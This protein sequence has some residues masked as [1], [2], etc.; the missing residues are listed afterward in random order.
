MKRILITGA[1]GFVGSYC[2]RRALELGYDVWAVRSRNAPSDIST[3]GVTWRTVD[4]LAPGNIEALLEE[5]RPTHALHTA[6]VTEHGAYWNSVKNLDWLALGLRFFRR[7]GEL[8]GQRFVS[9]GTC[10]EYDWAHGYMVEGLTPD[11]PQTFYGKIKLA[12]HLALMAVSEEM[13]FSAATGRIFFAY[14]PKENPSRFVPSLCQSFALSSEA[15]IGS[16]NFYRDFMHVEDVSNGILALLDSNINGICNVSSGQPARLREIANIL[17]EIS[18]KQHL[19]QIGGRQDR[20]NEPHMLVGSNQ[21]IMSTGWKPT[22]GLKDGL[23][24]TYE[25]WRTR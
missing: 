21:A 25:W 3:A 13:G 8:G 5:V 16:G 6:W 15:T 20:P 23:H 7:F 14:G 17:G 22:Y 18:G 1:S 4:L 10:A 24:D 19:L 12:H 11:K 9:T 2:V